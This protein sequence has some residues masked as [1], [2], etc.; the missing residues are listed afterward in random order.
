[1]LARL[2]YLIASKPEE[3]FTKS[4]AVKMGSKFT[5]VSAEIGALI[6]AGLIVRASKEGKLQFFKLNKTAFLNLW[7]EE[8]IRINTE[9]IRNALTF[10]GQNT[11]AIA[12][13]RE[14]QLDVKWNADLK[15]REQILK[16][17]WKDSR[18]LR[19]ALTY[20]SA[21]AFCEVYNSPNF[22]HNLTWLFEYQ[23]PVSVFGFVKESN[24]RPLKMDENLS[25]VLKL[26][27]ESLKKYAGILEYRIG[28]SD[29]FCI[30]ALQRIASSDCFL[31]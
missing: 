21:F 24:I 16:S 27:E 14:N 26:T 28:G 30:M 10:E 8:D 18:F 22:A 2:V 1:M 7:K 29:P 15:S 4:L 3:A 12:F 9:Q 13:D 6:K 17:V 31:Q 11:M 23:F 20:F 5:T 19:F 25:E